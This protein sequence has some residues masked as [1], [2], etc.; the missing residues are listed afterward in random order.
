MDNKNKNSISN[1][2]AFFDYEIIEKIETGI[3]LKGTEVKSLRN[4]RANFKDS[5]ARIDNNEVWIVNFHISP[6][7]FGNIYNHDPL[8]NRKLLLHKQE[9]KRLKRKVEEGGLTLVPLRLY[10]TRGKAK[11]ELALAKG[12]KSHDKRHD[13]S[14]RDQNRDMQRELKNKFRI[15]I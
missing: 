2:K 9:I 4:G 6:Y 3:I 8:R 12:K 13:I 15:N 14:K 7:E 1:R 5:Y 11:I 10:F